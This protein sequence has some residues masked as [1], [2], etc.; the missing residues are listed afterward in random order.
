MSAES[1]R[2]PSHLARRTEVEVAIPA[3]KHIRAAGHAFAA[4]AAC[5]AVLVCDEGRWIML[6]RPLIMVDRLVELTL[7]AQLVVIVARTLR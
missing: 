1:T 2:L 7:V 3:T 5:P 4:C 6:T